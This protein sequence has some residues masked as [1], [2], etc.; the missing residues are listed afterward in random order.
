MKLVLLIFGKIVNLKSDCTAIGAFKRVKGKFSSQRGQPQLSD[1][2]RI[3]LTV[4]K[5]L[6]G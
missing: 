1:T 2:F 3:Q 6:I 5:E 4:T